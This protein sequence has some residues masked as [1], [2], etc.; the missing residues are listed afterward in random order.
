MVI[1]HVRWVILGQAVSI[2]VAWGVRQNV[3]HIMVS[4]TRVW[5]DS[6]VSVAMKRVLITVWIAMCLPFVQGVK[7]GSMAN[8]VTTLVGLLVYTVVVMLTGDA[9]VLTSTLISH[10]ASTSLSPLLA[11][12]NKKLSQRFQ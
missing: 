12:H 11:Q 7:K 3:I 5:M 2:V 9:R 8:Y 4:A 10:I 1:V 6:M